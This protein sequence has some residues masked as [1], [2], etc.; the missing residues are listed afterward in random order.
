MN[1]SLVCRAALV[2]VAA[3]F[4]ACASTSKDNVQNSGFLPDYSLLK[5]TKDTR[6]N[7]IRA[8]AS[9]KL[10]PANYKAILL[11]PLVFHPEPQPSEQVS[12]AELRRILDYSNATLKQALSQRFNV[13]DRPGPGV[14]RL[15][16]AYSGVAAQG[17]GLKAYQYIP[18]AFVATMATRTATGTPQ[19]ALNRPGIPGDSIS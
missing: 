14:L 17:E 9:P 1:E 2:F 13:M 19:R 10:T 7:T 5:E 18:I 15:R 12:A 4:A 8:W 6:G 16:H 11:E 3:I